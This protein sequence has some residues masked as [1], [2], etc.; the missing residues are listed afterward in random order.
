MF[1]KTLL[2]ASLLFLH[3][4]ASWICLWFCLAFIGYTGF[5]QIGEGFVPEPHVGS[6]AWCVCFSIHGE[7]CNFSP[8]LG[9]PS[10]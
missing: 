5:W 4:S 6:P 7:L 9:Y 10:L 8:V 3:I 1:F 2:P